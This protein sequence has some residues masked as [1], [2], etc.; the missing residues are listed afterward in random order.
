MIK[1][2]PCVYTCLHKCCFAWI[3]PGLSSYVASL[4]GSK[5]GLTMWKLSSCYLCLKVRPIY[6]IVGLHY[7]LG[8]YS[9]LFAH[10]FKTIDLVLQCAVKTTP[11]HD[12]ERGWGEMAHEEGSCC[13]SESRAPEP[14]TVAHSCAT[15]R[16]EV[17][18]ADFLQARAG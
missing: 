18:T 6:W 8:F 5:T 16:W 13:M 10:Q 7:S 11:L 1:W 2:V 9:L 12:P 3:Q 4:K 17:E 15:V 14:S